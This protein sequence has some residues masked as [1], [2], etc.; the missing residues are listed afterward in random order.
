[1]MRHKLSR[2]QCCHI[3]RTNVNTAGVA[4]VKVSGLSRMTEFLEAQLLCREY[5]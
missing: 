2:Q 1:M 5:E 3:G 4:G